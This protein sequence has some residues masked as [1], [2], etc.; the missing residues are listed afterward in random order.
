MLTEQIDMFAFIELL[1]QV[2]LKS[3]GNVYVL[4][5]CKGDKV[6]VNG[7]HSDKSE[8]KEKKC[9]LHFKITFERCLW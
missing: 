6:D 8:E 2:K 4:M 9:L 3:K 1:V 5:K 7:V